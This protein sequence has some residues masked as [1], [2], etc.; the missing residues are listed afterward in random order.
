MPTS[1]HEQLMVELIN[2]ARLDPT[3]EAARLG[4]DLNDGFGAARIRGQSYQPLAVNAQL[5]D[6]TDAHSQWM[7]ANE[8]VSHEGARGSRAG[9]RI[10]AAGRSMEDVGTWSENISF[11]ASSGTLNQ[12]SAILAQHESLFDSPLHRLNM[13]RA[14]ASEV[15][16]GQ[17]MGE[18]DGYNASLITQNFTSNIQ[19]SYL[20]GVAYVDRDGDDF[21]SVGEG[22]RGVEFHVGSRAGATASAGGYSIAIAKQGLQTIRAE[23]AS[24]TVAL[25][26]N[27]VGENVKL[28]LIGGR[29]VAASGDLVLLRGLVDGTLLGTD[30]LS[31]T[32]NSRSNDLQGNSGHNRIKGGL[33]RDDIDGAGG[34]D[35][36]LGNQGNDR[37]SGGAGRDTLIGGEGGDTLTGGQGADQ[38]FGKSGIDTADYSQS[39]TA[40][41]VSLLRG[42]G[43]GGDAQS[44]IL[45][46]IENLNGSQFDDTLTGGNGSNRIDGLD[47]DDRIEGGNGRDTLLGGAG[48]DTIIGD[49]G[50]DRI[51]G[52]E[53][54]DTVDYSAAQSPVTIYLD[55]TVSHGHLAGGDQIDGVEAVI[56]SAFADLIVGDAAAN[57]LKGGDGADQLT[58]GEGN[59]TLVGDG[60][61]DLLQGDIGA[62]TFVFAEN[63]GHDV[64]LD[65]NTA[66]DLIE[67]SAAQVG[68]GGIAGLLFAEIDGDT[69]LTLADGATVTL[70]DV[71]ALTDLSPFIHIV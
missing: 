38:L 64:I 14:N 19:A 57:L 31:L 32:G 20:T 69:V 60:G 35:V 11:R 48:D 58:G 4:I 39:A 6:A 61:D 22:R 12:T 56:G 13:F 68:A 26:L 44:D 66:E 65:F 24:G 36:L 40:V 16:V 1:A 71:I 7:L 23:T 28:D 18:F 53:G 17:A 41:N 63:S 50:G 67:L 30:N 54:F 47:G 10:R 34:R 5:N 70:A 15:G 46:G 33:G 55:G 8:A 3:A 52:G 43:I 21:Y 51:S 29:E 37:L 45:R 49:R 62:D 59:D 2:R 42:N 25:K 27:F 9:D